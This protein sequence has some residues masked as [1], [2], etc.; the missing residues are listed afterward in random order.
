MF[1]CVTFHRP[2]CYK[3][4]VCLH[5]RFARPAASAAAPA[6]GL[7]P[8]LAAS[9]LGPASNSVKADVVATAAYHQHSHTA[10]ACGWLS[11]CSTVRGGAPAGGRGGPTGVEGGAMPGGRG[12]GTGRGIA[13][14]G[15]C[16]TCATG[17]TWGLGTTGDAPPLDCAGRG[18]VITAAG[19]GAT[20]LAATRGGACAAATLCID[21]ATSA[22]VG[23]NGLVHAAPCTT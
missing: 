10:R 21:A 22:A 3:T 5:T 9:A 7:L 11:S 18:A 1:C 2:M 17:G 14:S 6:Q 19:C 20:G 12:G 13:A 8:A 23:A 4:A 16:A 15:Y